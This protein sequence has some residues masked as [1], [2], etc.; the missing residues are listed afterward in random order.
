MKKK[1]LF[2]AI[3]ATLLC[4]TSACTDTQRAHFGAIGQEGRVSCYSGG[5]LVFDDFSTG[6]VQTHE[7]GAGYEFKSVTTQRLE[8][9]NGACVVDYGATPPAGWNAVLPR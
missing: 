5:S 4:A 2:A 9:V 6:K 1:Y 7:G 3:A 8:Q